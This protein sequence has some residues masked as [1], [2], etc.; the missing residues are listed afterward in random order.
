MTDHPRSYETLSLKRD[1]K[2]TTLTLN[3]PERMNAFDALMRS[4]LPRAWKE[5]D[6]DP[7][8][9]VVIVTGAGDRAFC[10]GMDL[11]EPAPKAAPDGELPRVYLT[12]QDCGVNKPVIAAVNGVCAGGGLCFV[13]D[14]DIVIAADTAYFTDARTSA[15]QVSIHG[16]L[17]LARK[18]PLEALF[19]MVMLGKA[20]RIDARRAFEI[21]LVGEVVPA[22]ELMT[23]ANALAAALAA[24]SPSA[25]FQT[26]YAIWDSL[27][28]G[29][30]TALDRGWEVVTRFARE[31][32]DAQEGARAFVEKRAPMWKYS[33]PPKPAGRAKT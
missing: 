22:S 2:V 10:A 29:L 12:A 1:G 11:R 5:I 17:R 13:S 23:R 9:W 16:T 8:T 30:H 33:P 28:H 3:R 6:E 26:K 14:A 21:G 25:I 24:N 15:G 19:R 27:D 20:G 4:E 32:P 31:H 7:E 18:I